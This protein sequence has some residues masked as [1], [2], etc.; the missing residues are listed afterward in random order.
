MVP[1]H[2]RFASHSRNVLA[3]SSESLASAVLMAATVSITLGP[4]RGSRIVVRCR[5]ISLPE[6]PAK[7]H[8]AL[9]N[10]SPEG[11]GGSGSQITELR[12]EEIEAAA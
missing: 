2:R 12:L 9:K 8:E 7:V 11:E 1:G 10:T 3:I 4:A 6:A 5:A